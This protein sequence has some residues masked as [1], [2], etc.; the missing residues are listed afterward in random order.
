MENENLNILLVDDEEEILSFLSYALLK[1][2]YNVR[3]ALNGQD[4]IDLASKMIPDMIILDVMMP[5]IDGIETCKRLKQNPDLKNTIIAFLSARSD[6]QTKISGLEVGADDFIEK[7]IKPQLFIAKI[8]SLSRRKVQHKNKP[9]RIELKDI[10]INLEKRKVR[11]NENIVNLTKIEYNILL[12]FVQEPDK[13]FTREEIYSIIWG[14]LILV[15]DRTLDVHVRNLRKKIGKE[16]I[17]TYKGVGYSF[18]LIQ[19]VE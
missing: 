15:G 9:G 12:M 13:I 4:A 6:D 5:G 2:G 8:K 18:N 10:R 19:N 11:V 7:P 3:T 17:Q 1:D 16:N 14:E